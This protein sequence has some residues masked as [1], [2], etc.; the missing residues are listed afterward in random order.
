M[1]LVLLR[2]LHF[3]WVFMDVVI[4]SELLTFIFQSEN[5]SSYQ[6]VIFLLPS[7]RLNQLTLTQLVT[8]VYLSHLSNLPLATAYPPYVSQNV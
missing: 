1:R 8:T 2:D 7:E 6:T 4:D 3:T 5:L